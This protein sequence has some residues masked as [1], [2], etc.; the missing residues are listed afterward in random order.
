M[1]I[2]LAVGNSF[3]FFMFKLQIP[4]NETEAL[5]YVPNQ[6]YEFAANVLIP[7]IDI[8]IY[9]MGPSTVILCTNVAILWKVMNSRAKSKLIMSNVPQQKNTFK[10]VPMLVLVSMFFV[11]TTIP[12]CVYYI[13]KYPF[14]VLIASCLLFK[15]FEK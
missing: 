15:L 7:W 3:V 1:T 12:V 2:I 8:V 10:M 4:L 9:G 14:S 11:V 5:C 13:S 6:H